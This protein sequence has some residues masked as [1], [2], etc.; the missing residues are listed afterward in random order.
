MAHIDF[1]VTSNFTFIKFHAESLESM[2]V[3]NLRLALVD[4]T[5]SQDVLVGGQ[6]QDPQSV[7]NGLPTELSYQ[8]L[9]ALACW[10]F[11]PLLVIPNSTQRGT[12]KVRKF[13]ITIL[14]SVCSSSAL[15][16]WDDAMYRDKS[17]SIDAP[18]SSPPNQLAAKTAAAQQRGFVSPIS[19]HYH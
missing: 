4:W 13:S 1:L 6:T 15:E 11:W 16:L 8:I 3:V 9:S 10:T 12:G 5:P 7:S 2:A 17:P 14:L 18:K 19:L